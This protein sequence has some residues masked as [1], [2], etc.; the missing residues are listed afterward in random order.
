M[1]EIEQNDWNTIVNDYYDAQ[2]E[3]DIERMNEH[4]DIVTDLVQD[5]A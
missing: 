2:Y 1:N 5:A 4:L 3:R